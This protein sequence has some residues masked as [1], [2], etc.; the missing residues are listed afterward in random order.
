[1]LPDPLAEVDAMSVILMSARS[2]LP[3]IPFTLNPAITIK[4]AVFE[5]TV[6]LRPDAI[7]AMLPNVNRFVGYVTVN[8]NAPI[9][10]VP[11]FA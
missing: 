2:E 11:V 8:P 7:S 3:V 9:A 5:L 4:P 6:R 10:V 1:M